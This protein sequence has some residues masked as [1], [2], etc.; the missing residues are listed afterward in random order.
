M[1]GLHPD[2][3][4]VLHQPYRR[5]FRFDVNGQPQ[6]QEAQQAGTLDSSA[7]NVHPQVAH[8]A[9]DLGVTQKTAQKAQQAG[10]TSE[11]EHHGEG[12]G[13]SLHDLHPG[14]VSTGLGL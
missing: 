11:Q 2:A 10:M 4:Q 1:K 3:K 14:L 8:R 6:S 12:Q 13:K 5:V 9:C 7:Q